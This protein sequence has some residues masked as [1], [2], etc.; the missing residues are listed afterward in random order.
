M[1]GGKAL[2]CPHVLDIQ[3][4]QALVDKIYGLWGHR[5]PLQKKAP[6]RSRCDD[7]TTLICEP[8]KPTLR[9]PP[10]ASDENETY[11]DECRNHHA[12]LPSGF[13]GGRESTA[14][15]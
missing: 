3:L 12:R 13:H 11:Q 2:H 1:M 4:H 8:R 6:V 10:A 5:A 7:G 9:E 14:P 15:L